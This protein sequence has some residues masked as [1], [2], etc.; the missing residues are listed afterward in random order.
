MVQKRERVTLF[1][2]N[3]NK[4]HKMRPQLTNN[5]YGYINALFP[6]H[7][8]WAVCFKTKI[9]K[10][11]KKNTFQFHVQLNGVFLTNR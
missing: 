4:L 11:K 7:Y 5:K 9:I 1:I 3:N 10:Q 6:K 8:L 2:A